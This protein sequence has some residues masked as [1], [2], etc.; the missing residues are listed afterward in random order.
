M[1]KLSLHKFITMEFRFSFL[2]FF[3]TI[4][5]CSK[6]DRSSQNL[7]ADIHD[8]VL[9]QNLNF[10]W[11]ILWGP[12][13]KIWMTERG[14]V[15]SRVDP[16]TG[17]VMPLLAIAEVQS[18][19]EGGMLGMVLHPNF[20][21]NPYLYVAYDY[22]QGGN[23]TGKVVRYQYNGTAL[24]NPQTI[25]DHIHA[26]GIHNGC[27]LLI[28]PDLKLFISTGDASNQSDPQ[29]IQAVNGKILRLNLDGSIPADNPTAGNPVW[30]YGHRNPQ[31]LVIANN[32]LYN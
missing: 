11:E 26:A 15:I 23:Y 25:I 30:T 29:N 2:L 10:P 17:T 1:M 31:G 7:P 13:N 4:C 5:S 3:L 16:A 24:I 12:D 8:T 19:G 28:T 18:Q 9:V 6:S 22:I 21:A 27:R 20:S 14:G 32:I